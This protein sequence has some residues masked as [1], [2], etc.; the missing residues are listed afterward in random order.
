M[1]T[2]LPLLV[3]AILIGVLPAP[4][5][6]QDFGNPDSLR[7]VIRG[8]LSRLSSDELEARKAK[9]RWFQQRGYANVLSEVIRRDGLGALIAYL[10]MVARLELALP[11]DRLY[12]YVPVQ[13]L[14]RQTPGLPGFTGGPSGPMAVP[15]HE[16]REFP[17]DP[18]QKES[19]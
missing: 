14:E 10:R 17:V 13:Q 1:Q 18:W 11:Q 7:A 9:R 5:S 2:T 15:L 12:L 4:S 16:P 6:A 19:P 3:L 8:E